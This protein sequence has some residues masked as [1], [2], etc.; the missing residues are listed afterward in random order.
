MLYLLTKDQILK[1]QVK[2]LTIPSVK[3]PVF[4][5]FSRIFHK[6]K[7]LREEWNGCFNYRLRYAS[8]CAS[9]EYFG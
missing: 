1:L 3:K 6:L 9:Q 2:F 8:V 5:T 7:P 4:E